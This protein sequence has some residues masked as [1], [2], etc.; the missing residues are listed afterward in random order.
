MIFDYYYFATIALV[1]F[2]YFWGRRTAMRQ[3]HRDPGDFKYRVL[4]D[5]A[6]RPVSKADISSWIA[7]SNGWPSYERYPLIAVLESCVLAGEVEVSYVGEDKTDNRAHLYLL[8]DTGRVWIDN[9]KSN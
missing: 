4:C 1:L 3:A 2:A 7:N 6:V 8:T 9:H 5:L